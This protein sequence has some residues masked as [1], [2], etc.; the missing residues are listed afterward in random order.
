MARKGSSYY[1]QSAHAMSAAVQLGTLLA[2][3]HTDLAR[4][5]MMLTA[6]QDAEKELTSIAGVVDRQEQADQRQASSVVP[7][8]RDADRPGEE[9]V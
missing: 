8:P 6:I 9:R 7:Q 2:K 4:V 1:Q 5:Q 3:R